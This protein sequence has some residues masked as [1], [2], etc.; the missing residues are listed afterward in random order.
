MQV[1]QGTGF[2]TLAIVP[3][4]GCEKSMIFLLLS[5]NKVL[6]SGLRAK[7]SEPT[8]RETWRSGRKYSWGVSC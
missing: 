2:E 8:G 7:T 1:M 4:E 3:R 5:E 6:P